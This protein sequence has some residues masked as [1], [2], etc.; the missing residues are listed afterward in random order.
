LRTTTS[1]RMTERGGGSNNPSWTEK[2]VPFPQD[3]SLRESSC[4]GRN[5][6]VWDGTV[7]TLRQRSGQAL[8]AVP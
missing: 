5:D 3:D 6:T 4:L 7:G 2:Q 1:L 8:K